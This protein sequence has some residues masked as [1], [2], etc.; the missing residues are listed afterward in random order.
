MRTRADI[1]LLGSLGE[2]SVGVDQKAFGY[3]CNEAYR[4]KVVDH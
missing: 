4:R 3:W 2:Q 1:P